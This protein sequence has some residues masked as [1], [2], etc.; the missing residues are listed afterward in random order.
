MVPSDQA[1]SCPVGEGV[2][3][4]HGVAEVLTPVA[5]LHHSQVTVVVHSQVNV[6]VG[7]VVVVLGSVAD[8]GNVVEVCCG[9]CSW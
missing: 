5:S 1:A 4:V 6:V 8:A 7:V 9:V 2:L 3:V